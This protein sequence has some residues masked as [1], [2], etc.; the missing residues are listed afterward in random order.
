MAHAGVSDATG[1]SKQVV[2]SMNTALWLH[3]PAARFGC[4]TRVP[5]ASA[6]PTARTAAPPRGTIVPA[7]APAAS[8]VMPPAVPVMRA[9]LPFAVAPVIVRSTTPGQVPATAIVGAAN[10]EDEKDSPSTT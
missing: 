2:L 10:A 8:W 3:A 5:V 7:H 9:V 4:R 6:L 1:D